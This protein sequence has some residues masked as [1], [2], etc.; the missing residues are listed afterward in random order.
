MDKK[1]REKEQKVRELAKLSGVFDAEFLQ[2]GEIFL[3]EDAGERKVKVTI[4]ANIRTPKTERGDIIDA[5]DGD[6]RAGGSEPP[7]PEEMREVPKAV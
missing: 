3:V 6:A 1:K 7:T 2:T 5:G 4:T